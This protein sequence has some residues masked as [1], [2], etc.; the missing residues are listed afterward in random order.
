M[1]YWLAMF[2]CFV[3][4][5]YADDF[6]NHTLEATPTARYAIS[7][8]P[9]FSSNLMQNKRKRRKKN[10]NNNKKTECDDKT[11]NR[12]L[13]RQYKNLSVGD[14]KI[15]LTL[16]RA[17]IRDVIALIGQNAGIN[18][19]ID[20]DVNGFVQA[21][22]FTDT[23][24]SCALRTLLQSNRP[25][26]ALIKDQN[27]HRIVKLSSTKDI[28]QQLQER[29]F[30][31]A[32]ESLLYASL[33]KPRKKQI[34]K[35]WRGLLGDEVDNQA[36]YI[37]FDEENRKIFFRCYK[38]QV[39]LFKKFLR[40]IDRR[41][42]Q[43]KIEARF[44]CAEKGFEENIG[45]QWSGIYNKKASRGKKID[46]VGIG[47]IQSQSSSNQSSPIDWA[48]NFLP[49][50][51]KAARA[52][53]IPF[54]FGGSDLNTKRLNLVL[55][56]AENRNEIKTILKPTVLTNSRGSA[57]ILVGETLPIETIIEESIEGRLRNVKTAHY[58][59]IGI[60]LKVT[61]IVAPDKKSV[62]LNIFIEN[63]Q[64]SDVV[65][66]GQSTYPVIRTTRSQT[67]VRLESGQTAMISGLM[68]DV[69][70]LYK[71]KAPLLSEFPLIGWLFRGRR[72]VK[73]DLQL[74]I[75]ITPTII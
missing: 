34:K 19:L 20:P 27:I 65:S 41:I 11:L 18:F 43:V 62:L 21:I 24:V 66:T 73:Q 3:S 57:E 5:V 55:N 10:K 12:F 26:L 58:K 60:Q 52:L 54:I 2:L 32:I 72:E 37:V 40:E 70:E 35:M 67:C 45:F 4:S 75:F 14:K 9:T 7:K 8:M 25:P 44:I 23:S 33:D 48:L 17:N 64:Q 38:E 61:P 49:T 46:F 50:P 69:R 22:H 71:K 6:L 36:F 53:Q 13:F 56:A 16:K 68:K 28:F 1:V 47:N 15:S 42:P 74:L 39:E 59:D 29:D 63:S 31:H 51:E 30:E